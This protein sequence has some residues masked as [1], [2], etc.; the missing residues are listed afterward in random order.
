MIFLG[1][2]DDSP[3]GAGR[4]TGAAGAK[5]RGGGEVGGIT[6]SHAGAA[7]D[8]LGRPAGMSGFF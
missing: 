4:A 8:P 7:L 2:P 5:T 3:A 6:G 1:R